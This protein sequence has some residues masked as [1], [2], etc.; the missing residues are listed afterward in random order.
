MCHA[1]TDQVIKV[2]IPFEFNVGHQSFPAGEYS[3]ATDAPG[4]LALRDS[5]SRVLTKV[6]TNRVESAG[7]PE[8]S[9]LEFLSYGDQHVLAK[10]W[11][12]G[13]TRGYE[14]SHTSRRT[15][16]ANDRVPHTQVVAAG[17]RP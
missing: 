12:Q 10:V 15:F 7:Q 6:L 2:K 16:I 3:I 17:T 14:L 1:Q 4:F 13:Q 8:S 9:K 11:R 5:E